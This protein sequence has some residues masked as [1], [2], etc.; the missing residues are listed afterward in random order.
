MR[1]FDDLRRQDIELLERCALRR[2]GP[3]ARPDRPAHRIVV[4]ERSRARPRASVLRQPGA[5]PR[6]A[7]EDG[8]SAAELDGLLATT[9]LEGAGQPVVSR[10]ACGLREDS[11][12]AVALTPAHYRAPGALDGVARSSAPRLR[13]PPAGSERQDRADAVLVV[14]EVEGR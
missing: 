11:D 5:R 6:R 1:V 8:S 2:P 10:A 4:P 13:E 14:H 3:G 12:R 9:V 7:L